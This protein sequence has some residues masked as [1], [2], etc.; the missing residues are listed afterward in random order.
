[1]PR[2]LKLSTMDCRSSTLVPP[3]MRTLRQLQQPQTAGERNIDTY[4]QS[5]GSFDCRPDRE[6]LWTN[7]EEPGLKNRYAQAH[8]H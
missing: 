5:D 7:F 2:V 6:G 1:M 4:G 3:S 8:S